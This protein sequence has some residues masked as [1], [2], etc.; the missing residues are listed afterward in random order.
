MR[1]EKPRGVLKLVSGKA[2][3]SHDP[4]PIVAHETMR[5]SA[6]LDPLVRQVVANAP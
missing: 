3:P 2:G 1:D 6:E 5:S 4:A